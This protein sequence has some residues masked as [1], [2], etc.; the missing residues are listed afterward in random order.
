M[1]DVLVYI[2]GMRKKI[3]L[4]LQIYK[5]QH[6]LKMFTFLSNFLST[7]VRDYLSILNIIF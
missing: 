2:I 3:Y 5:S 6:T 1:S 7:H 4:L